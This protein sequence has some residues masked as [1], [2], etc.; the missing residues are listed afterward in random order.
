MF[1]QNCGSE[2]MDGSKFCSKCGKSMEAI[3]V[4]AKMPDEEIID[5]SGKT[6]ATLPQEGKYKPILT[7][8]I[9]F[10]VS[11]IVYAMCGALFYNYVMERSSDMVF[12][13][14]LFVSIP[15]ALISLPFLFAAKKKAAGTE[16]KAGKKE[17]VLLYIMTWL[18]LSFAIIMGFAG[19][20]TRI[21][22]TNMFSKIFFLGK[23]FI[24]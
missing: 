5:L 19:V 18:T 20:F 6:D 13:A 23:S 9:I 17:T 12:M 15:F 22:L 1:C 16:R 10:C 3:E 14:M 4:P 24:A 2:I 7:A 11:L 8:A 21:G